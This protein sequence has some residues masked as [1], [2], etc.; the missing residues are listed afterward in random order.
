MKWF[1]AKNPLLCI[2]MYTYTVDP[3]MALAVPGPGAVFYK[4][5]Y[6]YSYIYRI[7]LFICK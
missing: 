5:L 4:L 3:P 7:I 2:S 1:T 6:F